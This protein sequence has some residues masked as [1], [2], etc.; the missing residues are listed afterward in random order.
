M[1]RFSI[2]LPRNGALVKDSDS[3]QSKGCKSVSAVEVAT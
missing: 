3:E 2:G 1:N